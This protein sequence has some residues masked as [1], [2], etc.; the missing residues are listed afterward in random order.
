VADLEEHFLGVGTRLG[1][2]AERREVSSNWTGA[3]TT[4]ILRPAGWSTSVT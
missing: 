2:G 3:L 1:R 4:V